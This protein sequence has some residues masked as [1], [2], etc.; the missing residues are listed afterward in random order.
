MQWLGL[1]TKRIWH[2][3]RQCSAIKTARFQD[4]SAFWRFH[5][6]TALHRR[7]S[8]SIRNGILCVVTLV[9]RSFVRKNQ[10]EDPRW[11]AGD[12]T[13][14]R[15]QVAHPLPLPRLRA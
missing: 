8:G 5:I 14:T 7:F 2:L 6:T 15:L 3:S 13:V 9:S 1:G 12:L 4:C 10:S 11:E